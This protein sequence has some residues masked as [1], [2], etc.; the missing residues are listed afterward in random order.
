MS[1]WEQRYKARDSKPE[2]LE[3]IREL[4][5]LVEQ[6]KLKM[7]DLIV[8]KAEAAKWAGFCL[9]TVTPLKLTVNVQ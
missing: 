4:R 8:R 9:A 3:Q 7:K 1:D 5:I 2:D 6:Q